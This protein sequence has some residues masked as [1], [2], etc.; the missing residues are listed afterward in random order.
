MTSFDD[1]YK[2]IKATAQGIYR[3]KGSKFLAFAQPVSS[4]DQAKAMLETY[5]RQFHDAHH[6]CFAWAIGPTRELQRMNDDGEPYGTAGKPIFG[7]ILSFGLTNLSVVVVRYFGGTK[8]GAGGLVSAYKAA[9]REAL[10]SAAII[11]KTI[12]EVFEVVFGYPE[13]NEVMRV[14]SDNDMKILESHYTDVCRLILAIRK[15]N[16][17]LAAQSFS[18]ISNVN[19]SYLRTV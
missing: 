12:N 3:E 6:H 7:Q 1:T 13:T 5:R 4:E 16:A 8:L 19:I 11:T 15:K 2:T 14:I 17:L 18:V 10:G 9:A